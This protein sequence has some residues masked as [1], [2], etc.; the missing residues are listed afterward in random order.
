MRKTSAARLV[1]WGGLG[2]SLL[3]GWPS[4]VFAQV[5]P[6][7]VLPGPANPVPVPGIPIPQAQYAVKFVCGGADVS[8]GI[9]VRG[10]YM[11]AINIHN[12]TKETVEYR[13]KTALAGYAAD[14]PIS[15]FTYGTT[16][17]DGAQVFV[18][19]SHIKTDFATTAPVDGF[20]VI[21]SRLPLDVTA[22]YTSADNAFIPKSL[23]FHVNKIEASVIPNLCQ[24][25]L[26]IDISSPAMW[27]RPSGALINQVPA[28]NVSALAWDAA[29]T[30]MSYSP[31]G[32][33][34]QGQSYVYQLNFCSCS[35]Q[36]GTLN[37]DVK[38]D[39]AS[40]GVLNRPATG[41]SSIF[42]VPSS[43][44]P[45]VTMSQTFQGG[46]NGSIVATVQNPTNPT[47]ISFTG[48]LN[49]NYGHA[50]LCK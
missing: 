7:P 17:P 43:T 11:T 27:K 45:P 4:L 6:G 12:P 49:L 18:C 40:T 28:A 13:F 30:W 8:S 15:S 47:G 44:A 42:N 35:S 39:D 16:G 41:Q 20:F 22:V 23:S 26:D 19:G 9:A 31:S 33:V 36:G 21:E 38:S 1:R 29:R 48:A 24:K 5:L 3:G 37:G 46:G 50:G 25:D 34:V 2:A 32:N 14:G 10:W